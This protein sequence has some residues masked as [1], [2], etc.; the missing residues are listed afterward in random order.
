[1]QKLQNPRNSLV[2]KK[3]NNIKRLKKSK[4]LSVCS[5]LVVNHKEVKNHNPQGRLQEKMGQAVKCLGK[6]LKAINV[7]SLQQG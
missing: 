7:G 6:E 5:F 2:R 4:L 1:M 3:K